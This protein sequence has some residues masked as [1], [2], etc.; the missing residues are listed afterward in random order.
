MKALIVVGSC[1]LRSVLRRLLSI[2]GF[3]VAEAHTGQVALNALHSLNAADLV[4]LDCSLPDV[5]SAEFVTSLRNASQHAAWIITL[6]AT[7][8]GTRELYKGQVCGADDFITKPF[9]SMQL[10]DKL[11]EAT[12]NW[13]RG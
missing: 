6:H 2:R 13:R 4:L 5:D 9:T 12:L 7:G 3:E 1:T 8:P 11:A 10:D